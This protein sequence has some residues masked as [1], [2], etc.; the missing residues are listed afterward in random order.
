MNNETLYEGP[1]SEPKESG[2]ELALLKEQA[3][4][5]DIAAVELGNR[6]MRGD[7]VAQSAEEALKWYGKSKSSLARYSAAL[8]YL[9]KEDYPRA[10][11]ELL[12][13]VD[14]E[15]TVALAYCA[16]MLGKLY[17]TGRTLDE[18]ADYSLAAQYLEQGLD[19]EPTQGKEYA[20]LLG[21]AYE[22]LDMP[23]DAVHWY[24]IAIDEFGQ[25]QYRERL[26]PIY[27]TGIV[28]TA[29]KREAEEA[30]G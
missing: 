27:L 12:L 8:I 29:K 18:E 25:T 16:L 19:L 26:Y 13:G 24:R 20:G 9:K 6:Y 17:L 21:L 15:D 7:G 10:E 1:V 11:Q 2:D 23:F 4:N 28:G 3:E 22:A 5:D 30:M 14:A